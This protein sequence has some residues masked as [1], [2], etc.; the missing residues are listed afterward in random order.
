M[1]EALQYQLSVKIKK[2]KWQLNFKMNKEL[3]DDDKVILDKEILSG[4]LK[5]N[6]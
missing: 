5:N 4:I 2:K 6:C 3:V 1:T